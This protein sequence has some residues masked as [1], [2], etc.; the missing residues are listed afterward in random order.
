MADEDDDLILSEL[1]D[2]ELVAQMFDDLY[3]GM[4]EEIMEAT[5]IL[6]DRGWA[7][8]DVLT[9][10]LVGGMTIVGNDFPTTEGLVIAGVA[11][12]RDVDVRIFLRIALLRRGSQCGFQRFEDHFARHALFV[13]N[14]VNH[15]QKL[16]AHCSNSVDTTRRPL[17][18]FGIRP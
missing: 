10:S 11:V 5:Q 14:R 3:D 8:Y 15:Q 2:E 17:V 6:L 13:G 4:R 12:D 9:K 1:D 7:P 16:F 18:N